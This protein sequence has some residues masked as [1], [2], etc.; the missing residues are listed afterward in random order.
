MNTLITTSGNH[1]IENIARN[2]KQLKEDV[3][4]NLVDDPGDTFRFKLM[5][6]NDKGFMLRQFQE[7][8]KGLVDAYHII[9]DDDE[10]IQALANVT[11]AHDDL[12][13]EYSTWKGDDE[14]MPDEEFNIADPDLLNLI[15]WIKEFEGNEPWCTVLS[16]VPVDLQGTVAAI[17]TKRRDQ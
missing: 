16:V 11:D 15:E 4:N 13:R 2:F 5:R 14:I 6:L 12:K 8:I 3:A 10:L 1:K 9:L 17:V 7:H